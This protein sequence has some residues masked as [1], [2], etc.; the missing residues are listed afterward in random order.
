MN[1]VESIKNKSYSRNEI[2][3]ILISLV[4]SIFGMIVYVALTNTYN[5]I[6]IYTIVLF[7]SLILLYKPEICLV[8]FV[9]AAMFKSMP[10]L[11]KIANIDTTIFLL[12]LSV[13]SLNIYAFLFKRG[14]KIVLD[15]SLLFLILFAVW[16]LIGNFYSLTP[17]YGNEK[18]FRF[19]VFNIFVFIAP[20]FFINDLMRIRNIILA[21]IIL[22]LFSSIISLYTNINVLEEEYTR[23]STYGANPIAFSIGI[24][25]A[26]ILILSSFSYLK[27]NIIKTIL[28]LSS[29][30][31]LISMILSNSRGPLSAFIIASLIYFLIISKSSMIRK[32]L[33]IIFL[34]VLI[35][36]FFVILP[37]QSTYRYMSI[38]EENP[39]NIVSFASRIELLQTAF[40]TFTLHPIIGV[41]TGGFA[42]VVGLP[43]QYPHN[44]VLEI[45]SENGIIGLLFFLGFFILSILYAIK[46]L[47]HNKIELGGELM[48]P[49]FLVSIMLIIEAQFSGD[50]N[51]N[52]ILFFFLG[53]ILTIYKNVKNAI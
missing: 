44:I 2:L 32:L 47:K 23:L 49:V 41:G 37:E 38:V 24:G 13:A 6:L 21:F 11:S 43:K 15:L 27:N 3:F 20:T 19:L 50:L 30:A 48:I 8:F 35:G 10:I 34:V 39:K 16:L 1:F 42:G 9:S 40:K 26:L 14:Y 18:S 7:I 29:P 28:L 45:L 17:E 5:K 31:L 12:L 33:I 36:S 4:I 46:I 52:R 53:I 25:I 22:G 51:D